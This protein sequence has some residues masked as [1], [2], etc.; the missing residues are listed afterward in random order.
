MFLPL[1]S[2]GR[3]RVGDASDA[4]CACAC[5]TG[6]VP[7][8]SI[9][10]VSK[11]VVPF[12][13]YRGFESLPLRQQV[14]EISYNPLIFAGYGMARRDLETAFHAV[15]F[16]AGLR[17]LCST[18]LSFGAGHRGLCIALIADARR[19]TVRRGRSAGGQP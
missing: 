4:I 12:A 5:V 10:A 2:E 16:A 11:T 18:H 9:G 8:R 13:G 3:Y 14:F 19:N 7:E 1:A 17:Q 6:E 15:L